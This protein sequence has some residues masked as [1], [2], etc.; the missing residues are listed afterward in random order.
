MSGSNYDRT[1]LDVLFENTALGDRNVENRVG[2]SP[3][4]RVSATEDGRA[5][6]EMAD[7]YA[8][9]AD[10]GFSVLVTEGTYPDDAHSQ[11]Y[12]NQPG[13]AS[14]AHVEAWQGVTER[15][16]GANT[17][18]L[19][20]LMHAGALVQYNRYT[21]EALAP[22]AVTPKG[23]QLELYG[24]DGTFPTPQEMTHED[25]ETTKQ[26]FVD[27]AQRAEA[28]GFDGVEIH[29]ANGY[30]LDEFLTDY[31]NDR[32]DEYGGPIEHR[33]ALPRRSAQRSRRCDSGRIRRRCSPLSDESQGS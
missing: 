31:T 7:Y 13:L 8:K 20:Q 5:T 24:G 19:A 3:M 4:T 18:I 32:E 6:S 2:L 17:P 21:D 33:V 27:A 1:S 28:A 15:V 12:A 14:Q 25:I 29:G 11:G 16:H 22:S 26:G 9:F 23:E 10:G 30:L